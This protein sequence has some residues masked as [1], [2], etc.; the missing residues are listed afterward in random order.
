MTDGKS[1][2][3]CSEKW[4]CEPDTVANLNSVL[5]HFQGV[6]YFHNYTS[7]EWTDAQELEIDLVLLLSIDE[8]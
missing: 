2:Y 3:F 7:G 5:K 8:A 6:H 4:R 1:L